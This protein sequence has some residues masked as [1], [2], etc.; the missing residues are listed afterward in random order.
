MIVLLLF[1]NLPSS[2]M[3]AD[4]LALW[5][6]FLHHEMFAFV[7][8]MILDVVFSFS[9]REAPLTFLV[10]LVWWYLIL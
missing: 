2:F 7:I 1:F 9:L 4:L 8:F 6:I 5:Y 3:L 10:H